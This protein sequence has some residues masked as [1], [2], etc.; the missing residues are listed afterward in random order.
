MI[1]IALLGAG[2]IGQIHGRNIAAS[3]ARQAGGNRRPLPRRRQ[4]A[5]G[6][7]RRGGARARRHPCR[8]GDRR[9]AD[10][11]AD[12]H[13]CR[14]HRRAAA[15]GKAVFCEKPVDLSS[16]RIRADA[17]ACREGRRAADDR[18]QPP[19]RPQFRGAEEA[20][21]RRRGRRGRAGHHPVARPGAAAGLLHRALGRPVPRHDDPRFR[22][23]A[24]PARRG[25]GRGLRRSARRWSIRRSARPATST[26]PPCCSRRRA[27]RSARSP[28]RVAPPMATT[29][30]SRCTARRACFRPATCTRRRCCFA[31]AEGF[32][33]DPVQNFFLERY[34]A[35]YRNEIEA[36]IDAVV[37]GHEAV[38][39]RP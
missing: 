11:H 32:T 7:D 30:A 4:R 1:S 18:L 9:G 22:H 28:I 31:G 37:D 8:Q 25:A 5:F 35:A 26:P 14:F 29:S 16:E 2:R 10:R 27:A 6:G 39:G 34:A 38:A 21:G 15:A 3:H 33:A 20:A 12:R 13:A 23:G 36:F 24:L 17:G 19:L